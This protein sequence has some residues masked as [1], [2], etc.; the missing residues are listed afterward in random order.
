MMCRICIATRARLALKPVRTWYSAGVSSTY[1]P[2][3]ADRLITE[4]LEGFPAILVVGP[5]AC[6]KTTTASRYARTRIRLDREAEAT[7]VKADPDGALQEPKP[8]LLDEW[9]EVPGVLGAVKRA[10]DSRPGPG[11]Y[12]ITGSVRSDLDAEGWPLTGRAIRVEMFGLIQ[13][14]IEGGA[15]VEPLFDRIRAESIEA[16]RGPS[17]D[18]AL[19]DY[20]DFTLRGGYP[21]AVLAP[22]EPLRRRWLR[23]YVD[24]V[25]RRDAELLDSGRDPLRLRRYLQVLCLNSA[26]VPTA[27]SLY[28]AAGI[29]AR[30]AR[31]YDRLMQN[32]LIVD[33]M[34]AWWN[35]RLKRLVKA[36]K[37]Y[38]IDPG[39]A[40]AILQV[41]RAGLRR[42]GDLL[43]RLLDTF[44]V[45]Q[46]RA[47]ARL[48]ESDPTLYHLRT[49][50]QR[51]EI[52]LLAEYPDGTVFGFEF[53]SAA[54]VSAKDARHLAWLRDELGD[55]FLGGA[56]LHTG[57]R[58]FA[59]G[60]RLIAAPIAALWSRPSAT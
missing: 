6:G 18:L 59:L 31:E 8:V 38:I 4:L 53:K 7:A 29:D 3:A 12:L 28:E 30:T 17:T 25:V 11:S 32:L 54:A 41:D 48:S 55:R 50:E 37:R 10:V 16:L 21:D 44:T 34:P 56:V 52:D 49:A 51:H 26:G 15:D 27:K 43:G 47:E 9:Q 14:E 45:S 35:N 1:V 19:N 57:P 33:E 13:R 24:Q 46:L 23:A 60:D 5:R 22:S 2:R 39:L 20:L 58:S 40:C 36:P 42:D